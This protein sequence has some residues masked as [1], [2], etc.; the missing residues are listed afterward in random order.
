MLSN[1]CLALSKEERIIKASLY[2]YTIKGITYYPRKVPVG[3]TKEVLASWYGEYFHG[4]TTALGEIYNMYAYSAAH[5]TYPLGTVIRVTNPKNGNSLRLR[6]NDRG[7]FWNDRG[8]DLSMAAAEFLG[9]KREGVAKVIIEVLSVPD[10]VSL[11]K[12]F[13][14]KKPLKPTYNVGEN[15]VSYATVTE[16]ESKVP[17]EVGSFQKKKEAKTYLKK[18]QKHFPKATVFESNYLYKV[19]FLLP[20]NEEEALIALKKLKNLGLITGYAICWSYD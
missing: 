19:K 10:I 15:A 18:F 7:P 9:T 12:G 20:S 5:K 13:S 1:I 11:Q 2:P 3:E 8:L 17:F 16:P 14:G 4:R 6:I